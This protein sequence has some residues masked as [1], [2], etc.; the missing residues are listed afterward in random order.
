[1]TT[2]IH[3]IGV[4][5]LFDQFN[6]AMTGSVSKSLICIFHN[7]FC[8]YQSEGISLNYALMCHSIVIQHWR[9]SFCS[10]KF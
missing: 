4:D 3:A 1:M 7:V 10:L 5:E 2:D 8:F 6:D 9:K